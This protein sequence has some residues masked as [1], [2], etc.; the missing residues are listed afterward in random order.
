MSSASSQMHG[1]YV[2]NPAELEGVVGQQCRQVVIVIAGQLVVQARQG[3]TC[4]IW[5]PEARIARIAT[6]CRVGGV[7]CGETCATN[8]QTLVGKTPLAPL[9]PDCQ[10]SIHLIS[11]RFRFYRHRWTLRSGPY[12]LWYSH[13][14]RVTMA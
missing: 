11:I 13:V 4:G 3:I 5:Q 8:K 14:T 2:V 1:V 9:S 10:H 7:R 12:K 6:S